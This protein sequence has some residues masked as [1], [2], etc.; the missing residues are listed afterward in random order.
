MAAPWSVISA[1]SAAAAGAIRKEWSASPPHRT[2]AKRK[3]DFV[4]N[5]RHAFIAAAAL[6][7][8]TPAVAQV[9]LLDLTTSVPLAATFDNPCTVEPE[10]IV[11]QGSADLSQR[12]WLLADGNLRLQVAERTTL[13]G[14]KTGTLLGQV[15]KYTVAADSAKDLAFDP[16]GFSI[17]Q[18]KNG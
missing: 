8:A 15:T 14:Y 2:T 11:F 10:V 7:A 6:L 1:R 18:F 16:V 17:L 4:K 9:M 13:D 12:V 5:I 3:G